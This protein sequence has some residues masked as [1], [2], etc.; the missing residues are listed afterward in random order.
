MSELIPSGDALLDE[1]MQENGR[2]PEQAKAEEAKEIFTDLTPYLDGEFEQEIPTV[3]ELENGGALF[4]KGRLNE[5]HA[6]PGAG[7]SNVTLAVCKQVLDTGGSVLF[8]DPE[9][10]P[11]SVVNRLLAFGAGKDDI[12]CRLWYLHNPTPKDIDAAVEWAQASAPDLVCVDG[13]AELMAGAG[14]SERDET[15]VLVFFKA[16]LRPFAETDAAVVVSDHVAKDSETRG[17]WSRGS[18][19]KMGRYDG[20][21]YSMKV[22]QPYAPGKAGAVRLT[23]AKDRN[24]GVGPKGSAVAEI[25]FEPCED[26]TLVTMRKPE[27][28]DFRPTAIM[29]KI[30]K[31]LQT[32]PGA[33]NAELR[34]LGGKAKYIDL[35][36]NELE[37]SGHLEI[38]SSGPG[39]ATSYALISPFEDEE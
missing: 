10:M 31:H 11:Q 9:D 1:Y 37:K 22:T 2:T 13:L 39:K 30:S 24:G 6:E 17:S 26:G 27:E 4:Y 34:K 8:I 19:A 29:R 25:H 28:G 38:H 23:V 18:G 15:D 33:S 5:V 20:A 21:V 14:K 36:I 3:G 16:C 12:A 32:N 7:K 35:A